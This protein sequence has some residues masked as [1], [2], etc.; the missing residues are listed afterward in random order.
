MKQPVILIGVGEM[1]SVFARGLLRLGHPVFPVIRDTDMNSLAQHLP[2]PLMVLVSVGEA[3]LQTVLADIPASWCDNIALLQNELLPHDFS[4]LNKPTVISVWFE[5]KP[6][7]DAKVIIPSPAHGPH[8]KLLQDAL[9]TINIPVEVLA[10]AA[11]LLFHL[12]VKN[13][14]ILTSN[15][16]GMRTGGTVHELWRDHQGVARQVATDVIA[17]QEAMT[18]QTFDHEQ[19]LAAMLT[20]F[21]GDPEHNCMG[22]SAPA[23]LHRAIEHADRLQLAVPTLREIA[24]K[25]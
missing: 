6:G 22:R 18:G 9:A 7:Q 12:V 1:G 19:L 23:R 11:E 2:A 16:A 21:H 8:A 24:G 3:D 15:I 13:I 25:Q 14:Y 10:N 4:Q 5:K 20:A 17:L